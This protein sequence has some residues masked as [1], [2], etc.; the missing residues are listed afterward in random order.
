MQTPARGPADIRQAEI[1]VAAERGSQTLVERQHAPGRATRL[2]RRLVRIERRPKK[3]CLIV[4]TWVLVV[5]L[6]LIPF[7]L[8]WGPV[9]R[10]LVDA[11]NYAGFTESAYFVSIILLWP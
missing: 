4:G 11:A 6:C 9:L 3:D 8:E 10:A 5:A 1:P 2:V 7:L